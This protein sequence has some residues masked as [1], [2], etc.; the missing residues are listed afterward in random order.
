MYDKDG[1]MDVVA[2]VLAAGSASRMGFLKQLAPWRNTTILLSVL[3]AL[4]TSRLIKRV[5]LVLGCGA[6]AIEAVVNNRLSD[7]LKKKRLV[8]VVNP[9][10]QEGLASSIR[11][12][13]EAATKENLDELEGP[14]KLPDAV[15]LCLGDLPDITTSLVERVIS[16]AEQEA[17]YGIFAPVYRGRR[18]HPVLFKAKYYGEL[19]SLKGDQG[20]KGILDKFSDDVKHLTVD[21]PGV[22][23]DVDYP[24]SLW[25]PPRVVVRGGGDLGSGVAWRLRRCGFP[26]VI[27]ELK[28]PRAVR[29][30]VSFASAVFDGR[31]VVEGIECRLVEQEGGC[32]VELF[33]Q[34]WIPVLIDPDGH[35]LTELDF[36]VL[37]DARMLKRADVLPLTSARFT[38]ALGPG[39]KAPQD[40]HCVIE[41][42][43]GPELG[44]VI[45]EGQAEKDTGIP[46]TIDGFASERVLHAPRDGKFTAVRRI[47]DRVEKGELIGLV[48]NERVVAGMSGLLRGSLQSGVR[49]GK[50]EKLADIDPRPWV[51]CDQISDKALAVAGG[52]LEAI[53]TWMHSPY[54]VARPL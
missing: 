25:N 51:S 34:P 10:W 15:L 13:V 39:Y 24:W 16:L 40:V 8:M 50:G 12:G 2:V 32:K 53:L 42:K 28:Q 29:R 46:G 30:S 14:G 43:R 33:E 22:I 7:Y 19:K 45:Y 3:E 49:V 1:G 52:V 54:L 44:R 31:C 6:E 9:G 35:S 47:G 41:T 23:K 20:A 5:V 17:G 36:E 38:I 18:G 26:V 4:G 11:L 48:D 27:L 37:V 21:E